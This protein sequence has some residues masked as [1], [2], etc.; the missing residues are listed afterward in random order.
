MPMLGINARGS[1]F[2]FTSFL[3][4]LLSCYDAL[5]PEEYSSVVRTSNTPMRLA[6]FS[7]I[8]LKCMLR[9]LA[10]ILYTFV[11]KNTLAYGLYKTAELRVE[12]VAFDSFGVKSSC[13]KV[14]T[15]D[16]VLVID[17]GIASEVDSF[18]LPRAK[19][20]KLERLYE[21]KIRDVCREADV[22]ILTHYHYDHH[23]PDRRLYQNK[24]LLV[25]DPKRRIN[26]SQRNRASYLLEG[27]DADVEVAD[28]REFRFGSTRVWFSRPLWHG[29]EGTSLGR[30]LM[31]AIDDGEEKLLHTSDI[32]GPVLEEPV[33]LIAK[34][35]PDI[36]VID[37]PPTYILGYMH[38]YYN[39]ARSIINLTR[40]LELAEPKLT[41]LDHHPLRDYRY[42]DLLH[43]L[44][45]YSEETGIEVKT[46]AELLGR[47]PMVMEGYRANGPTKWRSWSRLEP[48]D[49]EEIIARAVKLKLISRR[50]L[51]LARELAEKLR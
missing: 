26:K 5:S 10:A 12:Y 8:A 33:E 43:P 39:L 47:E 13:V 50:W 3:L 18:P 48:S 36:L 31:V 37:G 35:R 15:S 32:D 51:G 22:I 6:P 44:Y 19:R 42:R 9:D 14:E 4:A 27:I 28:G 29:V 30:V 49:L 41:L 45:R 34:Q 17:P 16:C 25:K 46:A 38:A 40:I 2:A 21:K 20:D 11:W 24:K 1:L 23:I 7:S